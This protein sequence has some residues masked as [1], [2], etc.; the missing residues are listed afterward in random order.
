[1]PNGT[2]LT[3]PVENPTSSYIDN[4]A[5]PNQSSQQTDKL[6]FT[7]Y[8]TVRLIYKGLAI[9]YRRGWP[10]KKGGV[11]HHF[12]ARKKGWVKKHH[13]IHWGWVMNN[14]ASILLAVDMYTYTI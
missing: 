7:M 3:V 14:Y 11:G 13:A 1:M 2:I 10:G 4:K 8:T 6:T 12:C 9:K 5:F